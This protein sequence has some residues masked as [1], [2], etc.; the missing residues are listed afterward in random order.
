MAA[1]GRRCWSLAAAVGVF[2]TSESRAAAGRLRATRSRDQ[3][4][5]L[6]DAQGRR[7]QMTGYVFA[8]VFVMALF[9]WLTDKTLEWVLYDLILGWN[10]DEVDPSEEPQHRPAFRSLSGG[11]RGSNALV[12]RA[13]LLRHGE[14][15]RAQP[16]RAHRPRRH[17]GQVRPHPGPHRRSRRDE[18]RQEGRHRAPLLPR[19]RAG[20]DGDGR[21]PWHLVKHTSKV[22]GFVGGA[23]PPGADLR[24]RGHED[25]QPDAGRRRQAP[26]Q[27]GV[28]V[29][30]AGARQGRPPSP[31]STARSRK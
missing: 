14:G 27:G 20:R 16:A 9:L 28:E 15:G 8:F 30:E 1:R 5:R 25:R 24:G 6:A 7:R 10:A 2:F 29:G 31:T 12:R 3:E 11:H 26:A 22:T 23:Q 19:L 21:R 4:G 18:E 17:A 13:R